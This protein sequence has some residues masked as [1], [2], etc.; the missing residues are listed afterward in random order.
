[1][2]KEKISPSIMTPEEDSDKHGTRKET[3]LEVNGPHSTPNIVR[4]APLN[5]ITIK[6]KM[7]DE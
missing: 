1:M 6:G 5:R 7:N 4:V 2:Q 3:R